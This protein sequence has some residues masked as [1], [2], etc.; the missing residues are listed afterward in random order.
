MA[1]IED[2]KF[3]PDCTK[4]AFGAHSSNSHLEV[5]DVEG[6]KL[7]KQVLIN[8]SLQGSLIHLDWATDN[9]HIVINSSNYELKFVNIIKAKDVPGPT[10]KDFDWYTWTSV[11]GFPVQGIYRSKEEYETVSLCASS[12]K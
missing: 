4:V 11:L 12:S 8:L 6:S 3:S 9:V 5:W 10:V 1:W 7:N 2:I